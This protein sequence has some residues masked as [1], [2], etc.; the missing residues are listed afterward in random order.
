MMKILCRL[1]EVEAPKTENTGP[2]SISPDLLMR[3]S[4]ASTVSI[5]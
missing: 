1:L 4:L 3:L 5:W 2:V